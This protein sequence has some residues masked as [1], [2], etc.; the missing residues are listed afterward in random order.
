M[1][2]KYFLILSV[3]CF[4]LF[5]GNA[6]SQ[7]TFAGGVTGAGDFPSISVIDQN[8]VVV[9]GGPNGSPQ[10]FLSTNGG[11]TFTPITGTGMASFELYCGWAVNA[12][13][14]FAGNGGGVGGTGGNATFY[15]TTNGGTTWSSVLSTG[16]SA[17]FFNAIV[18]SRSMP[19]FGIGQSDP[20]TGVGQPYYIPVTTDGGA[21]WTAT[22]PPGVSGMASA[23]NATVVID[24]QFYG[25][26][27]G[28]TAPARCYLTSNGGANW[29]VGSHAGITGGFVAGLAFNDDKMHGIMS[30]SNSFPNVARTTNGGVN[31]ATVSLGGSGTTTLSSIKWITGTNM[32]YYIGRAATGLCYKSTNN[33]QT[34]T[35]MTTAGLSGLSHFDFVRDGSNIYGY[36]IATDGSVLKLTDAVTSV[37]DPVSNIPAEFKLSQNYPNPFNPATTIEFSIPQASYVTLKVYNALGKEVASIVDAQMQPGNYS[38]QFVAAANLGSGVYFYKLTAGNFVETKK[39]VLTK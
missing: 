3:F 5:S 13:T 7:W 27:L 10:V 15:R 23:Q 30:T 19:T 25:F 1:L 2:K 14:M 20:P 21:T 33:G 11:A 24:D 18:F 39:F 6:Y 12:T 34:W 16:S 36:C 28:N 8:T 17:G 26:G 4:L 29:Y 22:F 38:Q 31:W 32:A 35:S 37:E 9:F